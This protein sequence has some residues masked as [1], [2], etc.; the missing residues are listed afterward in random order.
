MAAQPAVFAVPL[1]LAP[2]DANVILPAPPTAPPNS[3]DVLRSVKYYRDILAS[4]GSF[5]YWLVHCSLLTAEQQ[6]DGLK[7]SQDDFKAAVIYA[8]RIAAE[9]AAHDGAA[10]ANG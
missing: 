7:S 10:A 6:P 5:P 4:L 2:R 3:N 8:H 9:A 1:P